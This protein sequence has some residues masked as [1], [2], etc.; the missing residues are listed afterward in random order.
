MAVAG[1]RGS[2]VLKN[3][4]TSPFAV[5]MTSWSLLSGTRMRVPCDAGLPA[6]EEPRAQRH[7]QGLVQVRVF[8]NDGRRFAAEFQGNALER[9]GRL[10]QDGLADHRRAGERYL[11]DIGM[12][13]QFRAHDVAAAGDD[14]EHPLRQTGFM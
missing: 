10:T 2:P 13:A 9:P 5:L 7:G 4:S 14:I 12:A 8:Q 1:S 11:H 3:W 6:V